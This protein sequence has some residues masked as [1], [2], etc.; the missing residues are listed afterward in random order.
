[1]FLKNHKWFFAVL[2]SLL[3]L[4]TGCSAPSSAQRELVVPAVW[5]K[6]HK[7]T[8]QLSLP[9]LNTRYCVF[10]DL[11]VSKEYPYD[12]LSVVLTYAPEA[13]SS[14][15]GQP[16]TDTLWLPLLPQQALRSGQFLDYRLPVNTD[17]IWAS[18]SVF[19][20]QMEHNM[21]Q[22]SLRGLLKAGILMKMQ[23][24]GEK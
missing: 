9:Q 7:L 22:A 5:E 17:G 11:R 16:S 8:L 6:G 13:L 12:Y 15:R 4:H 2:A 21:P 24:N 20:W 3:F 1:M 10:L 14:A 23:E 19:Y 18:D